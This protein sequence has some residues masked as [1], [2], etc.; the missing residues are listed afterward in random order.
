VALAVALALALAALGISA[1]GALASSAGEVYTLTNSPSGNAVQVFDRAGNGSLSSA[2]E[3]PTGGSGTGGDLGNQGAVVL[4][5]KRL[6]AVNAGSDSISAF[7]VKRKGLR[8]VD[9]AHSG[10]DQPISLTA[11][12]GLLYVLNAG[13]AGNI[14]GF[15]FSKHGNLSPL[16]GSTRPLSGSNTGPA[17]VSFDPDGELLVVTEK[18]T[19]LIDIYEVDSSGF[20]SGPNPQDSAGTTPFGFAFDRRG[21]LI[22]SEASGGEPEQS[23]VSS[24]EIDDGII[25]PIT[26]SAGTTETAACWIVITKNG[27]FAYTSNTG[28]GSISGFRVGHAGELTLLDADGVTGASGPGPIDMALSRNSRFLYSLNSGDETISGFRVGADGSL[29]AIGGPSGLPDGANGLAAR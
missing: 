11:H 20:A 6:F 16:A 19:N 25:D 21:H 27:R 29:T 14:S 26:P 22:V 2:G 8:L 17:Q 23:A 13:G 4:D 12:H 5:R 15:K 10:G 24:Y 7:I 3:F 9:T 18:D 1:T 28:S